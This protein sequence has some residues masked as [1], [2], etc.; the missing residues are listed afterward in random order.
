M[1]R[2]EEERFVVLAQQLGVLDALG[3]AE[4]HRLASEPGRHPIPILLL[5]NDLLSDDEVD[6]VL[7]AMVSRHDETIAEGDALR[8]DRKFTR[9]IAAYDAAISANPGT[10]D[11]Y[12]GR[13]EAYVRQGRHEEALAD[14]DRLIELTIDR[15]AQA[16][17]RR[18]RVLLAL[19]RLGDAL[20]ELER[21]L[22]IDPARTGVLFDLGTCLQRLGRL[23]EAVEVY[24]VTL[25]LAPEHVEALNN[26][27][28]AHLLL[29]DAPAAIADWQACLAID[30]KRSTVRQNLKT[31]I[32]RLRAGR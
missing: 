24:T 32:A 10:E 22:E 2:E 18:G 20:E 5:E 30:S 14:Y 19:D 31:L 23:A 8:G 9:A 13:A 26:R 28:I 3:A 1:L 7:T 17:H 27:A 11:G 21:S 25:D 29:R 16:R 4:V 15:E 12:W 6:Q